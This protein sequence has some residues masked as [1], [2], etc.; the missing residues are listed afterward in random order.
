ME[1][2]YKWEDFNLDEEKILII[3]R[4]LVE[5]GKEDL[6]CSVYCIMRKLISNKV[7]INFNLKGTNREGTRIQKKKFL[8]TIS[9]GLIIAPLKRHSQERKDRG[10]HFLYDRESADFHIANW[11]K[12]AKKHLENEEL[13]LKK[14]KQQ[15]E[16]SENNAND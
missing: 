15:G 10:L 11:L 6:K 16:Q 13:R 3:I 9:Y 14:G 2:F 1:E 8:D 12:D 5:H 7:A 4:L